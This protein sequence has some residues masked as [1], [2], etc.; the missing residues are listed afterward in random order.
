LR[1]PEIVDGISDAPEQSITRP[2]MASH[3]KR[4]LEK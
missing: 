1:R 2:R 4:P 3:T